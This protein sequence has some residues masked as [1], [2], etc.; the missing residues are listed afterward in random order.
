[1]NFI[2]L[3]TTVSGRIPRS[4]YWLGFVLIVVIFGLGRYLLKLLLGAD[5]PS[6][7]DL[8]VMLWSLLAMVPLTALIV[9]R[10]HDR[11]RPSWIGYAVG[12]INALSISASYFGYLDLAQFTLIEPLVFWGAAAM[13]LFAFVENG[14]L[15]GTLGPNR[16]GPEPTQQA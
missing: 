4:S 2:R 12:A 8:P 10:F 5:T 1:M 7:A 6:P 11:D 9:K 14:F 13:S 3:F 16:Y 15:R